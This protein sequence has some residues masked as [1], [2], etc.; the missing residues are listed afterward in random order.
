MPAFVIGTSI[1]CVVAGSVGEYSVLAD[2]LIKLQFGSVADW[3]T[4]RQPCQS[5]QR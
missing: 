2:A 5:R 4:D 3:K 1:L